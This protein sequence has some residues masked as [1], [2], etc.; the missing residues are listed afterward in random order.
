[1]QISHIEP[2][3]NQYASYPL[4]CLNSPLSRYPPAYFPARKFLRETHSDSL[5]RTLPMLCSYK[6]YFQLTLPLW[7]CFPSEKSSQEKY[8]PIRRSIYLETSFAWY[9]T[10]NSKLAVDYLSVLFSQNEN[11]SN[12]FYSTRKEK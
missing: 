11:F 2:P 8:L 7:V 10:F 12:A 1:M 5:I 4:L 3:I 9:K 6:S